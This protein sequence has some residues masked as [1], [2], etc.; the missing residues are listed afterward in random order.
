MVQAVLFDLFETL[1]TESAAPPTRASSL[2]EALGLDRKAY[3]TEW[4]ARRPRV[5]LGRLSFAD[6]LTEISR[7]LTG[8]V[9]A[10][11]VKFAREQRVREK[12]AAFAEVHDDVAGMIYGLRRQGLRLAVVSNCFGEDVDGWSAW[13]LAREFQCTVF[14]FAE[15][16]S[17]PDPRSYLT[18]TRRLGVE[19]ASALFI[20]DGGDGELAGAEQAGIRAFRADW[21]ARRWPSH[22]PSAPEAITLANCHDVLEMVSKSREP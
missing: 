1:I 22:G 15:G 9:D 8:Q 10:A 3:R 5:V 12:A 11:A 20:G 14:S 17:K 21:F 19:P 7:S 4:K 18:A 16:I 2:G 6:A 13:P